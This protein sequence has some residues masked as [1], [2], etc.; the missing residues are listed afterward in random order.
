MDFSAKEVF[1]WASTYRLVNRFIFNPAQAHVRHDTLCTLRPPRLGIV[2]DKVDTRDDTGSRAVP[3]CAQDLDG[4]ELGFLGDAVGCGSDGASD[5]GA[6]AVAI[7][8]FIFARG[9]DEK[10][11]SCGGGGG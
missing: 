8:E 1:K 5:V 10:F 6:V 4:E 11:G 2:V 9:V 3:V 7:D